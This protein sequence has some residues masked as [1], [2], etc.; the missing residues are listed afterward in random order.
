MPPLPSVVV[1]GLVVVVS[2][3]VSSSTRGAWWRT[4]WLL[5]VVVGVVVLVEELVV[6]VVVELVELVDVLESALSSAATTA[7]ATPSPI[8]RRDQDRDDRLHAG[9]HTPARRLTVPAAAWIRGRGVHAAG[10]VLVHAR[11]VD[12]V[13][14]GPDPPQYA[15]GKGATGPRGL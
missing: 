13:P 4:T 14:A 5:V 9:A 8:T 7:S 2:G 11:S 15:D 3:V 1:P 12:G 10:G 6:G